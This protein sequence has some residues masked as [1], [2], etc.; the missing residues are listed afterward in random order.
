MSV[1]VHAG[2]CSGESPANGGNDESDD[3]DENYD[4]LA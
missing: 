4:I 1:T 3:G 2:Y